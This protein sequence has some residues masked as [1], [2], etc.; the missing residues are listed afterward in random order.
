[1]KKF[2]M[3][4]LSLFFITSLIHAQKEDVEKLFDDGEF[5]Y[6]TE[7]YK[8]AAFLFVKLVNLDPDNAN[9]N[10]LAGI[11]YLKV[12]GEEISAIPYLKKAVQN[13]TQKYK[14]RD[15]S[16]RKAPWYAWYYLGNA[17]RINNQLEE[18]LDAYSRF[19]DLRG[20]EKKYNLRIV[21][22]EIRAVERAK[23]IKDAPIN[24]IIEKLPSS[25]DDGVTTFRPVVNIN[26]SSM[27]FM[28]S[29]KFY[30]AIMYSYKLDGQWVNPINITPQVGSDGDMV[31]AALSA[32]GT[33]LLLV[34][35]SKSDK[36]DIYFSRYNGQIWSKAEKMGKNIN[37]AKDEAH[38]SFSPDGQTLLLASDRRGGF[39][40]LDIYACKKGPDGEWGEPENLGPAINTSEDET[41]AFLVNNG[42]TLFF[43][44]KGHFNMGGYDIFYSNRQTSGGWGEAKNIGFP[45]NTTND[46]AFFQPTML[47]KTG[48]VSLFQNTGT[49]SKKEIYH[50]LILPSEKPVTTSKSLFN[51][52]FSLILDS[53]D[54][55]GNIT[56][57]Y[58]LEKDTFT[59]ISPGG[60]SYSVKLLPGEK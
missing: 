3:I 4:L 60:K 31:P 57:N 16:V 8:E 22:N 43:S 39:G 10:Y 32:D 42:Q 55:T 20:F 41:S 25:I 45:L 44:S 11:S 12:N 21:Q 48:Y 28:K 54:S 46:N 30:D 29:L 52:S 14:E 9:Y 33:E 49:V 38:A 34:R 13:T 19:M 50:I 53:K 24:L 59:V 56:I 6:T 47:G 23:I 2:L 1:M 18:A 7:E 58:D 26:E 35:S 36:G 37:T 40:G 5:F 27:V 51:D 15:Q 17:Y